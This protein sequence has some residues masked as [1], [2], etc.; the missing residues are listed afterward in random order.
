MPQF[1]TLLAF[2]SVVMHDMVGH[3]ALVGSPPGWGVAAITIGPPL[4]LALAVGLAGLRALR[5][6][7]SGGPWALVTSMERLVTVT[8]GL[9]A[10]WHLVAVFLLGWVEAVRRA[11][12]DLVL[13]DELLAAA[14][15][16]LFVAAG[17]AATAGVQRRL[18]EAIVLRR[19]EHGLSA[20]E[21]PGPW[22]MVLLAARHNLPP[23]VV[24]VSLVLGWTELVERG[25]AR[26]LSP[27]WR[28][29]IAP[30]AASAA[31]GLAQFAGL[32]VILLAAPLVLRRFWST[33]ELTGPVRDRLAAL[34]QRHRVR[35][36]TPLVWLTHG[37]MVNGAVLG[38][39]WPARY[40]LLTDAL[41]EHLTPEQVEAVSAHEVGHIRRRHMV[42]LGACVMAA[43]LACGL[44]AEGLARTLA[45]PASA[46][47]NAAASAVSLIVAGVVFLLVSRR[48]EWQADAFAVRHLSEAP[49]AG[50]PAG[51]ITP[52][53]AQ[54]FAGALQAVADL[55]GVPTRRPSLRH[56]SIALRQRRLNDM[57]GRP[58]DRLPID[59][60]AR[61]IKRAAGL[62][63]ASCLTATV[64]LSV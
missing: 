43:L 5:R 48:L 39:F 57:V 25:L 54:I 49:P 61:W 51:V 1:L 31:A 26:A 41:L 18:R 15:P 64:W 32:V 55:N 53:A 36:G 59:R 8:R 44:A 40:I 33:R 62:T 52:E 45:L 30:E 9:A 34:A 50:E 56:G 46:A 28:G 6:L 38:L 47:L 10:G 14:P 27:Q 2:L 24:P 42:W 37:S 17:W 19:L 60:Q 22:S 11:V 58:L 21:P 3:A 13:I 12:G 16:V 7:D 29:V 20:A 23:V 4:G 35:L 63:L